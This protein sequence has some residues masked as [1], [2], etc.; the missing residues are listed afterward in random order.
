ML[1]APKNDDFCTNFDIIVSKS[2]SIFSCTQNTWSCFKL[3]LRVPKRLKWSQK[4]CSRPKKLCGYQIIRNLSTHRLFFLSVD[5][6][7]I[8]LH[9]CGAHLI[10]S[11]VRVR[12][13]FIHISSQIPDFDRV[14]IF[15]WTVYFLV[16]NSTFWLGFAK[17]W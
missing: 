17:F 12:K 16:R 9:I 3:L 13:C 7:F 14:R 2:G 8:I 15:W 11:S 6:A 5:E 1:S 4:R 10:T